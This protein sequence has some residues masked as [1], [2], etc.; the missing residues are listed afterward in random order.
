MSYPLIIYS[1]NLV[2]TLTSVVR[3]TSITFSIGKEKQTFVIL[4]SIQ[5]KYLN[6]Y[7]SCNLSALLEA[8]QQHFSTEPPLYAKP[9]DI[10]NTNPTT[11]PP[12][13]PPKPVTAIPTSPPPP[14]PPPS[15]GPPQYYH[16]A[17]PPPPPPPPPTEQP[18]ATAPPPARP[19][20]NLLDEDSPDL[21]AATQPTSTAPPRPTNPELLRL[22]LQIHQ[23]LA[24]DLDSF[25]KAFALDAERLRAQQSDLQAG[26]PAIRDEMAR[27][28]A[29]KDVCRHVAERLRGSVDHAE[30]NIAEL[31]R[32]GDPEVDELVCATSIVHNQFS[33][34]FVSLFFE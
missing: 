16:Q 27:L 7:Q 22:H 5:P 9:K 32:K 19:P 15:Q 13:L 3:S 26:E 30:R 28:E 2:I 11:T 14:P 20:P 23:K 8:M 34:F 24:S 10:P 29:V 17:P 33:L 21:F 1:S 25:R 6:H 18:F 4:F 31:R 12:Q